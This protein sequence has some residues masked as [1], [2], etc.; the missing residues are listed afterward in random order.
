MEKMLAEIQQQMTSLRSV[1]TED[2]SKPSLANAL[3]QEFEAEKNEAY[4]LDLGMEH[5]FFLA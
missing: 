4:Y 3:V 1:T 2:K 5:V